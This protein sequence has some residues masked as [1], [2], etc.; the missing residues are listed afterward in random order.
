[1]KTKLQTFILFLF[2]VFVSYVSAVKENNTNFSNTTKDLFQ[3][4]NSGNSH[5]DSRIGDSYSKVKRDL[6]ASGYK[7]DEDV[8]DGVKT[9]YYSGTGKDGSIVM[10]TYQ[11]NKN[12]I[13]IS[14]MFITDSQLLIEKLQAFYNANYKVI[15]TEASCIKSWIDP[16]G[17]IS[18]L[19]E[20]TIKGIKYYYV[21]I[22][23]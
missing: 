2:F 1:M 9:L 7:V 17:V 11:F 13:C 3:N 4:N 22:H 21:Y 20:N 16:Y 10:N 8:D 18:S 19:T 14:A 15:K 5:S 12:N 23:K 6:E